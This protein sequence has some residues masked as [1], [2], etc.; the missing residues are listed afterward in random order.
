MTTKPWRLTQCLDAYGHAGI[1]AASIW[2]N[3]V[4]PEEGGFG[5]KQAAD[6]VAAS[7]LK[8]PAY[9]RGGFFPAHLRADRLNA[10]EHNRVCLHEAAALQAE[11]LVLVVGAVPSMPLI[12]ARKQIGC[13]DIAGIRAWVE[14][15]G[16]TGFYEVEVFSETYWQME[17][18]EYLELITQRFLETV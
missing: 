3:V 17:Q 10:I 18:D 9:V 7:G 13:I 5:L 2:R 4:A 8:I 14:A 11:M 1:P 16:F 12:E 15:T 6:L